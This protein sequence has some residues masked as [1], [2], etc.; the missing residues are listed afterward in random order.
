MNLNI[1]RVIAMMIILTV[2]A[3]LTLHAQTSDINDFT[4][5]K[6]FTRWWWFSAK[7]DNNDIKHQ[8]DWVK[9]NEFGGVEI[10]W[11]Y[12]YEGDTAAEQSK[13]LSSDWTRAVSFAKRYAGSLGLGCDFT[14]GTLWPFGDSHVPPEEGT[15]HY[16]DTLSKKNMRLTWEHPVKGRVIN[17]LN[18]PALENYARRMA[19]AIRPALSGNKS[20]LFCDSWEVETKKLWTL[21]FDTE[22]ERRFGYDIKPYMDSLYSPGFERNYYDYMKQLSDYVLYDF[23][24]SFT[25]IAQRYGAFTRVQCGGSPTDLLTAFSLVDIPETEAMLFEPTFARIPASAAVLSSK[26]VVSSET[27]TCLYGWKGWPGPGPHQ[28]EE[29]IADLKLVADALFANSVNM[30]IW[31]GMPYNPPGDSNQFFASVHVG[32]NASFALEIPPFNKY[33]E[34]VTGYMRT[35]KPYTS[36]AL[37]IPLEDSWMGVE[38]PDSLQ[39]PWAWGEYELRY[40]KPPEETRGFQPIWINQN[41][42]LSISQN[43]QGIYTCGDAEINSLYIDVEYME[44]ESLRWIFLLAQNGLPVCLKRDPVEPGTILSP[45]YLQGLEALKSLPNVSTNLQEIITE[46]ALIT[47]DDLPEFWC[48]KTPDALY[49]FFA[50]PKTMDLAFPLQYGQSFSEETVQRVVTINYQ[51]LSVKTTLTFEPYQSLLI[52][53]NSSGEIEPV[54]INFTPSPPVTTD[55]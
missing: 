17:H 5:T 40:I 39:F 29:H 4:V 44:F 32:P 45:Q 51:G 25:A 15:F 50:N 28:K 35:G 30:I 48:R 8:L 54:N 38:Y 36:M 49:I 7:I 3:D 47:G 31:H 19:R 52:K 43:E 33:L 53:V 16:P 55:R 46:P 2:S 10:A 9:A 27:F 23:Y 20:A 37:Y 18:K 21:G 26:P 41:F 22:F 11:V 12:P 34:K 24:G 42:L 1:F 13:W 14:F 6:P